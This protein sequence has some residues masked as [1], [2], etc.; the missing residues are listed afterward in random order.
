MP[1]FNIIHDDGIYIQIDDATRWGPY[2]TRESAVA[3]LLPVIAERLQEIDQGLARLQASYERP[4]PVYLGS[5]EEAAKAFGGHPREYEGLFREQGPAIYVCQ[6]EE[7]GGRR[8]TI[9][10]PTAA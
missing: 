4:Q 6:P 9:L 3:A 7:D 5:P 2:S 10:P 1:A 8:Q